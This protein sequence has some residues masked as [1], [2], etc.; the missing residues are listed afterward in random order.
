MY[1]RNALDH[2][3]I[4]ADKKRRKPLVVRG[5][6]QVGKTTLI[7]EFGKE[8]DQYLYFNLDKAEDRKPFEENEDIEKLTQALF[9]IKNEVRR[10]NL[11]TLLFIDEIQSLPSVVHQLRYFFEEFPDLYV[12]AAG[13][14][15]ENLFDNDVSFPVG[16]VEYMVLRPVSFSEFLGALEE[17][18]AQMALHEIPYPDFAYSKLIDLF[19]VYA[20]TG[21]M[22][23]IVRE[24]AES[25]D[26]TALQSIYESLLTS[27]LD[28][29]EKYARSD[30]Q[31]QYIRHV[32]NSSFYE[33]GSRITFSGFGNSNYK[34]REM[35]EALE[36][37][38]KALLIHIVYPTVQTQHPLQPNRK[39]SPKLHLLDTGLMNY[40]LDI[41]KSM[42]GVDDLH[43]IYKGKMIEHLVG[44]EILSE[45]V[46]SLSGLKFW[47]RE[48]SSSQ[49]ELDYLRTV[50]G[51]VIP[52]EVKSGK[53]GKLKSLH[54]FMDKA[55]SPFAIRFNANK[56]R[57]DDV[58]ATSGKPYK[59]LNLPYFLGSRVDEYADWML[60]EI[61]SGE[62]TGNPSNLP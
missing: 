29:V 23:E 9:F 28:D 56:M 58:T 2:L 35:K 8:F 6:R 15:L 52:I 48:K 26:F 40:R 45:N 43:T 17:T 13:S 18:S 44:Q 47:V 30:S 49:A 61:G 55:E 34:S 31:V 25:R 42:L 41:Q 1:R 24:Y 37:L 10:E 22:P 12:V 62:E 3:R 46:D 21:G 5:A 33:A 51:H 53:A 60:E 36:A 50:N 20:I 27:Y 59:L 57:I 7:H 16:R 38:E 14:M 19:H 32:I 39:K 54:L 4:W 11:K